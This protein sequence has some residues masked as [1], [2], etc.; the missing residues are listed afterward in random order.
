MY[1]KICY[2]CFYLLQEY[3]TS[4]LDF[5]KSFKYSTFSKTY[6]RAWSMYDLLFT[7]TVFLEMLFYR[8]VFSD[9]SI[10]KTIP[11]QNQKGTKFIK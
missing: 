9:C 2:E 10:Q 3:L 5:S 8:Y 11:L 4:V 7:M 6:N 1:Q